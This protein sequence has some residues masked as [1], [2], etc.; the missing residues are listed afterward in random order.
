[1]DDSGDQVEAKHPHQKIIDEHERYH[2]KKKTCKMV[3]QECEEVTELCKQVISKYKKIHQITTC[4]LWKN[5][6]YIVMDKVNYNKK[7]NKNKNNN[8]KKKFPFLIPPKPGEPHE[9]M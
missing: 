6:H 1:M 2:H 9:R 4:L 8:K 7:K 3:N 5:H